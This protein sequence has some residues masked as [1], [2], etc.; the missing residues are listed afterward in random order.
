[1]RVRGGEDALHLEVQPMTR[2]HCWHR[3]SDWCPLSGTRFGGARTRTL[4]R[5]VPC[6]NR[7]RRRALLL[8][9]R[10]PP[11]DGDACRR[12]AQQLCRAGWQR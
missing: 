5:R 2:K 1:M 10:A 3:S 4:A 11:T 6:Q 12:S 7:L 9:L 8:T